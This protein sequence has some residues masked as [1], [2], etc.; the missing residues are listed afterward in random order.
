LDKLKRIEDNPR[1]LTHVQHIFSS[2]PLGREV[3]AV[4]ESEK[5]DLNP[6][7][8]KSLRNT[9]VKEGIKEGRKSWTKPTG[10]A[11]TAK[12]L[13]SR[14]ILRGGFDVIR[15]SLTALFGGTLVGLVFLDNDSYSGSTALAYL[16]IASMAFLQSTFLG[17]RYQL[18]K[19]MWSHEKDNGTVV[20]WVAFLTSL[21]LRN[22][23]SSTLEGLS[24]AIPAYWMGKLNPDM[25]RF[26][27]FV[28]LLVLVAITV[29]AQN[30]FVEIDRIRMGG[31]G[32]DVRDAAIVNMFF[33]SVGA[34]FNGFIIQLK[35]IP[36]YLSWVPYCML[37]FWGF[38]GILV[39]N[40]LDFR[41]PCDI[42]TLECAQRTGDNF[43]REFQYD[44][45]NVYQCILALCV[46]L[47]IFHILSV[48]DFWFRFV[49]KGST[50]TREDSGSKD[51]SPI[52]QGKIGKSMGLLMQDPRTSGALNDENSIQMDNT[53][54]V[55]PKKKN[56]PQMSPPPGVARPRRQPKDNSQG[57]N[58]SVPSD[59]MV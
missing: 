29:I 42:S 40:F 21:F 8:A 19:G 31:A 51:E 11:V 18:E 33:I 59:S 13:V 26:I 23:V 53:F 44:D 30:T 10:F 47:T 49:R 58:L 32:P 55:K 57:F 6:A 35:D 25:D 17:D 54:N 24:F 12:V 4:I 28:L 1:Q 37:T 48:L 7:L 16:I 56:S 5:T 3:N 34:L 50:L 27:L 38:V 43:V 45:F 41:Y 9:L 14:T 15:T 2:G 39:N 20:S 52:A 46:I 22:I 36:Q